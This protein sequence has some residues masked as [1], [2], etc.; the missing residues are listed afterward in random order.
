MP[1]SADTKKP[2]KTHQQRTPCSPCT[3]AAMRHYTAH[4]SKRASLRIGP[5][6]AMRWPSMGKPALLRAPLWLVRVGYMTPHTTSASTSPPGKVPPCLSGPP[7]AMPRGSPLP[8]PTRPTIQATPT[9]ARA[10]LSTS[11][12][13]PM[14]TGGSMPLYSSARDALAALGHITPCAHHRQAL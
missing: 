6:G 10:G 12:Q 14:P 1:K 4:D 8:C 2:I 3:I 13:P 5:D 7:G 11:P 9:P